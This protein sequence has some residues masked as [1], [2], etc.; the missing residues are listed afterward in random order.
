M[1]ELITSIILRCDW[2]MLFTLSPSFSSVPVLLQTAIF[3]CGEDFP[4]HKIDAINPIL[5]SWLEFDWS[6][7]DNSKLAEIFTDLSN[8]LNLDSFIHPSSCHIPSLNLI[9][10]VCL[11]GVGNSLELDTVR[12][13]IWIGALARMLR[14]CDLEAMTDVLKS[15]ISS[16]LESQI[17]WT[18]LGI[19]CD[20]QERVIIPIW[21]D[22]FQVLNSNAQF[23]CYFCDVIEQQTELTTLR[24]FIA[25]SSRVI[26][27]PIC[28]LVIIEA[29]IQQ[30]FKIGHGLSLLHGTLSSLP[31]SIRNEFHE[32]LNQTES[33]LC[34]LLLLQEQLRSTLPISS[35]GTVSYRLD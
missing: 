9:Q 22:L 30:S 3:I 15:R 6:N 7:V 27:D 13:R 23:L 21:G 28:Q 25:T 10:A 20:D 18:M 11:N 24:L 26:R 2:S 33:L 8:N 4:I 29:A 31:V 12:R 19:P 14:K 5:T 34:P 16:F 35:K 32:C 17:N 1:D